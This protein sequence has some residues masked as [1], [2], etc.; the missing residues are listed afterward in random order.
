MN[1]EQI[2]QITYTEGSI[3]RSGSIKTSISEDV[4]NNYVLNFNV[5]I[6]GRAKLKYC[7]G[8]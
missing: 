5:E 1:K 6:L 7:G 4:L 3:K 8:K 2:Y